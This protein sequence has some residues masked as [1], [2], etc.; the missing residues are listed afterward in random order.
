MPEAKRP[1]SAAAIDRPCPDA[2]WVDGAK[3]ET[4]DVGCALC[5]MHDLTPRGVVRVVLA[6]LYVPD[7]VVDGIRHHATHVCRH[8]VV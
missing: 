3:M 2:D 4:H 8:S 1:R 7:P 5:H 6:N